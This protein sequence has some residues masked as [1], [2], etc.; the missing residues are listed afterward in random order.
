MTMTEMARKII[1]SAKD[2]A[3][4]TGGSIGAH[5]EASGISIDTRT[6]APGDLFAAI[7][8]PNHD[9]HDHV[10]Q[11]LANGATAAMVERHFKGDVPTES[12]RPAPRKCWRRLW[13]RK[14]R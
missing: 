6:L 13:L 5:W 7:K 14:A 4:A 10:A 1:W 11:A 3:K 2:A 12:A 8:G 9:G